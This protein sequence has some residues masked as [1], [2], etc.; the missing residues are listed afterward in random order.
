MNST[1]ANAGVLVYVSF[2]EYR[3]WYKHSYTC[4]TFVHL[5]VVNHWTVVTKYIFNGKK[6]DFIIITGFIQMYYCSI[7]FQ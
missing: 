2:I 5:L 3:A 7:S 1:V 6:V 4:I